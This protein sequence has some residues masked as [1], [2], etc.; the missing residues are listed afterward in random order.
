MLRTVSGGASASSDAASRASY[1]TV[2]RRSFSVS[3]ASGVT[4]PPR[5]TSTV[6]PRGSTRASFSVMMSNFFMLYD[7]RPM[8]EPHPHEILLSADQIQERVAELAAEIR[9]DFP[10]DLHVVAVLKGAFIFL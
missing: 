6:S 10:G 3:C 5:A 7:D 1:T 2:I 4:C 9:R 8:P